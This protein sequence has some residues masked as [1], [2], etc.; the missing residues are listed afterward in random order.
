MIAGLIGGAISG[1]TG[2]IGAVGKKNEAF[3]QLQSQRRFADKQRSEFN[4]GYADLLSQAKS[5]PTYQ[6]DISRFQKVEQQAELSKRLASG[7]SRGAG[8]QI[9]RDQASQ[10]SANVLA[11]ATRGAGSGTDIMTAALMAQQGE[12]QAQNAIS[13]RSSEQQLAIQN[14]AQQNQLAA[15]GQTA[16]ASARERGLEFSSLASKQAGIMG[17][18]QNKL[19]GQLN[20]NQQL[21]DGEQA[22]AAALADA[23]AAIWS[24]VGNLASGIGSG[25]MGIQA[26]KQNMEILNRMYPGTQTAAAPATWDN[27]KLNLIGNSL[28]GSTGQNLSLPAPVGFSGNASQQ[29]MSPRD[30]FESQYSWN[31]VNKEWFLKDN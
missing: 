10:T 22:K 30:T 1:I 21:F 26:Q 3:G 12:N 18:S 6:G 15:L 8:E 28:S 27:S 29:A 23:N 14:Q 11:A 19:S 7:M 17:V 2:I 25:L 24:G 16:A 9:A 13:A 31:P 5:A 4:A 20:L